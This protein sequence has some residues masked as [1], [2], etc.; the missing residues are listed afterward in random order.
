MTALIMKWSFTLRI[1]VL[2]AAF[3]NFSA[4]FAAAAANADDE[5]EDED[6]AAGIGAATAGIIDV[7]DTTTSFSLFTLLEEVAPFKF[8]AI[9]FAAVLLLESFTSP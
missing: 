5:D 6:G 4:L 7:G 8:I 3:R 1:H 9:G 2:I